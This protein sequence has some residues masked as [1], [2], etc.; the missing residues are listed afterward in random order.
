MITKTRLLILTSICLFFLVVSC[1]KEAEVMEEIP[2]YLKAYYSDSELTVLNQT[3][4][5]PEEPYSYSLKE[6]GVSFFR[7]D[8]IPAKATLG[9]VLFY[10]K[11]L[12][13][14]NSVSCASCH[15]QE[16]AFSDNK[17]FSEGVY[18][19]HTERNSIAIASFASVNMIYGDGN[20]SENSRLFWDES[21]KDFKEQMTAT[22]QNENEMGMSL[23]E[24]ENRVAELEYYPILFEKIYG[25]RETINSENIM[26][27]LAEFMRAITS[28]NSRFDFAVQHEP[29]VS[30]QSGDPFARLTSRENIGKKIF[31]RN[32]VSC[33]H[34]SLTP[35]GT[36]QKIANNGLDMIYKD[37]GVGARSNWVED[38]GKFKIPALRNIELTA[39]YMHDGRFETLEDV[40]VFYNS[41]IQAH[42]N[43]DK[44]LQRSGQPLR[45]NLTEEEQDGLVAFLETLTDE[46]LISDVRFSDPF[47]G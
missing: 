32:C 2:P 9:R 3:L 33:H 8:I 30:M 40:V 14:D 34:E 39:P 42:P 27:A 4:N 23:E 13:I 5:L 44:N 6:E 11:N 16:L 1:Q 45:L 29:F 31:A 19:R 24:M 20:P 38:N 10:D 15:H 36:P 28:K 41:G 21:A 17:A 12:S 47:K 7:D 22:I 35:F 25:G 43:L 18:G 46:V 26:D 37:K